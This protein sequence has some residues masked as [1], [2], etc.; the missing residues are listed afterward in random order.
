M[1]FLGVFFLS[2]KHCCICQISKKLQKDTIFFKEDMIFY[3]INKKYEVNDM[4]DSFDMTF[5]RCNT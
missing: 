2:Y 3:W 1:I 4:C 5:D